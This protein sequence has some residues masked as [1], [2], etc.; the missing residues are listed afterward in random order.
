[1]AY[2]EL[3]AKTAFSFLRGASLPE[4]VVK[5][6]ARHDVAALA[7]CERNGVYSAVRAHLAAKEQGLRHITGAEVTMDDGS[8]IPLL[9]ANPTG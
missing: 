7:V 3:H 6:C 2:V 5:A 4:D 1:M 9:V 8:A